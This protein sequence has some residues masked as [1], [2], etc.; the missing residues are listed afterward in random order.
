M[1]ENSQPE[2]QGTLL[3]ANTVSRRF[4][5]KR[6]NPES[7]FFKPEYCMICPNLNPIKIREKLPRQE[8]SIS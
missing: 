5:A 2:K 3:M 8:G 7:E 4:K 1:N 6:L